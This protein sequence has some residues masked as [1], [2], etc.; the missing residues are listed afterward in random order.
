MRQLTDFNVFQLCEL[1]SQNLSADPNRI[2]PVYSC[3]V[4]NTQRGCQSNIGKMYRSFLWRNP[5]SREN[6]LAAT[7]SEG[8]NTVTE[9]ELQLSLET[10]PVNRIIGHFR[11][12]SGM[13]QP[14]RINIHSAS[15]PKSGTFASPE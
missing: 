4:I 7:Y 3:N 9:Q 15:W 2:D 5:M 10:K 6:S 1:T 11:L 13:R 12:K 8:T 14:E